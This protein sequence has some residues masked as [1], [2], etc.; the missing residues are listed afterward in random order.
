MN[1]K[2]LQM[3]TQFLEDYPKS[4]IVLAGDFNVDTLKNTDAKRSYEATF[5]E[6]GLANLILIPTRVIDQS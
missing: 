6:F 1:V 3:K 5:R 4:S 2:I